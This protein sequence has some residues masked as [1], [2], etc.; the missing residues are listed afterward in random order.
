MKTIIITRYQEERKQ[1]L[2]SLIVKDCDNEVIFECFTLELPDRGNENEIS[3]IPAGDYLAV[4]HESPKFGDTMWLQDVP[5]RSE[6]LIHAGNF[7]DD[8]LGCILVGESITDI[9]G[10]GVRDV[11]NSRK[12]LENLLNLIKKDI[13]TVHINNSYEKI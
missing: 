10:D 9:D 2:G 11:T 3:R 4:K 13:I 8:T 7:Y 6:I 1:T 5:N 12:T